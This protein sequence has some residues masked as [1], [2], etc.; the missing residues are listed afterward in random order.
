M[1]LFARI[2][3]I[4][5]TGMALQASAQ[6]YP[7]RP[8]RVIIAFPP[9]S[10]TDIIGRLISAKVSEL[11]GQQAVAESECAARSLQFT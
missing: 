5:L 4:A 1:S 3:A 7:T 9:G 6:N 2:V 11:W 8:V 10:A